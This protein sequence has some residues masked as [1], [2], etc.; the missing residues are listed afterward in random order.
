[1]MDKTNWCTDMNYY[2]TRRVNKHDAGTVLKTYQ[3][4]TVVQDQNV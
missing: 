3:N 1:M 4:R 2:H